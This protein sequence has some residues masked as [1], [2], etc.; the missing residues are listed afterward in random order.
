MTESEFH[1]FLFVAAVA[2]AVMSL[3]NLTKLRKR[4]NTAFI[5]SAA[6]LVLGGCLL[7]FRSQGLSLPVAIG[8]G[9]VGLLLVADL[10]LRAPKSPK[11]SSGDSK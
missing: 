10:V 6:F 8:G 3:F 11:V 7:L 4:G 2:C 5:L 9:V 1:Q